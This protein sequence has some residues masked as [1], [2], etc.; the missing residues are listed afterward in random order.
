MN[1]FIN[2]YDAKERADELEF[3]LEK[4]LENPYIK[5]IILF[6]E[7]PNPPKHEKITTIDVTKRPTYQDFF[8][9]TQNYEGVNIIS[10]SD[11]FFD[12]T[13]GLAERIGENQCYALTR[14]EYKSGR[15]V[16]FEQAHRIG[17][18]AC[19]AHYTQDSWIIR[20]GCKLKNC[21][22]VIAK[23]AE[24]R[25]YD[26]IRFTIGIPGCDNV[27]AAKLKSVYQVSNPSLSIKTYHVHKNSKRKGY[28]HRITG[29]K[30]HWGIIGKGKVPATR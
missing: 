24:E 20:G 8:D 6:N 27:I 4:N 30:S 10:N 12:E 19:P 23:R 21:D 2:Y 11:I 22:T 16:F 25:I 26:T 14:W 29:E 28:S 7:H 15:A 18:H 3:C 5:R 1:L 13:I 9:L 17:N